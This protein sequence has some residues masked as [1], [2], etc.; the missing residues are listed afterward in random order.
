MNRAI[1]EGME[2]D[3]QNRPQSMQQWL[4]LLKKP[5]R[6]VVNN[7]SSQSG[8]SGKS[9]QTQNNALTQISSQ[10]QQSSKTIPWGWLTGVLLSY[11]VLGFLIAPSAGAGSVGLA[12]TGA[13]VGVS[14]LAVVLDLAGAVALSVA[15]ENLLESFSRFHTFLILA[16]TSLFGLGLGWLSYQIFP[17]FK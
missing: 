4:E 11:S 5:V 8:K 1:L 13:V 17:I 6:Q 10:A 15:S 16:A 12:G 3:A 9:R 7:S 14:V 2:V